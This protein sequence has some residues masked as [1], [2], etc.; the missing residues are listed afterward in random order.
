MA[1]EL[2]IADL[3]AAVVI[4]RRSRNSSQASSAHS[5]NPSHASGSR[6][7]SHRRS[8]TGQERS[9]SRSLQDVL[10]APE[11]L[12]IVAL[13]ESHVTTPYYSLND[14]QHDVIAILSVPSA[15]PR[16]LN[17]VR[18]TY[19]EDSERTRATCKYHLSVGCDKGAQWPYL[20]PDDARL[21]KGTI[22]TQRRVPNDT[23]PALPNFSNSSTLRVQ[24]IDAGDSGVTYHE[25]LVV[26]IPIEPVPASPSIVYVPVV[27]PDTHA[28]RNPQGPPT[29][30]TTITTFR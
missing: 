2:Q 8:T 13:Q 23:I 25:T 14:S 10:E 28:A 4:E 12:A 21:A 6:A 24:V 19:P 17:D 9:L 26:N 30:M 29:V 15:G 22:V 18:H 7:K 1:A 3:D 20:R 27:V 5:Q 16:A 11:D